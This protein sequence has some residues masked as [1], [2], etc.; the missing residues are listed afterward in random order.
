MLLSVTPLERGSLFSPG[1]P[2]GELAMDGGPE[3]APG[4]E[5]TWMGA[6]MPDFVSFADDEEDAETE[7]SGGGAATAMGGRSG[8]EKAT[9]A[10]EGRGAGASSAGG[11]N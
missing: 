5:R 7:S 9:V 11:G 3:A 1:V 10:A 4:V 2:G 6:A 8:A